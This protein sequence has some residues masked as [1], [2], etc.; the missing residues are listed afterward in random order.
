MIFMLMKKFRMVRIMWSHRMSKALQSCNCNFGKCSQGVLWT[1]KVSITTGG[2]V[3][4][5][6][7]HRVNRWL[8]SLHVELYYH[9]ISNST[10]ES[11]KHNSP[12]GNER[13]LCRQQPSSSANV[14]MVAML[15]S[16]HREILRELASYTTFLAGA[17]PSI[18]V[19]AFCELLFGFMPSGYSFVTR[20]LSLIGFR[21]WSSRHHWISRGKWQWKNLGAAWSVLTRKFHKRAPALAFPLSL[22]GSF[23]GCSF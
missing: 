20:L 4:I 7:I 2:C 3:Q 14:E 15:T 8:E 5:K 18:A 13:I 6:A 12:S 10:L 16:D 22:Y 9:L 19:P 23:A 11:S 17:L 21:V 1:L